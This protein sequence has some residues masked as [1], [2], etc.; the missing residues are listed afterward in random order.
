MP[1][2]IRDTV[3]GD[4]SFT[5]D[6]MSIIDTAP[7]QRLRGIKQL[8]TSYLVYPCAVH[9]RFE[10][11]LGTCHVAKRI[12]E[13]IEEN[14]GRRIRI[15]DRDRRV[16]Y[17]A[18]LL[19]DITHIPFGHTFEDERRIFE[20]HDQS[21]ERLE[22]FLDHSPI[23]EVLSKSG[24]YRSVR[25]VL[26][27]AQS[28]ELE[29]PFI[30]QIVS[31]TVC[32]DLLDYLKRDALFC[33]LSQSYDNR[34]FKY[35]T[36]T[37][38]NLAFDL[39]KNGLFRHDALSELINLLRIRYNL[40]ERVYYHHAK[41][42]AGAMISKA[43]ELALTEKKVQPQDLFELRDDSF[44]YFLKARC[45]SLRPVVS[46]LENLE[47]RWLYKRIYFLTLGNMS[48][49]GISK[50][51]QAELEKLYHY[52]EDE[53]RSKA[54]VEIARRL[55]IPEGSVIIYCPSTEMALKEAEVLVRIS[56]GAPRSLKDLNN[57]EVNVLIDKHR[58]LW[59][60]YVC[61]S[62]QYEDRFRKAE[63]ICEEIFGQ[64]N[65]IDLQARGQLSLGF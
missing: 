41:I 49:P 22:C 2:L 44:I 54:E 50:E 34:V 19:H 15:E 43:L 59:R 17:S 8:G 24:I 53:A 29:H 37:D 23:A 21:R 45:R 7:M 51:K 20:R 61:I 46:L 33:G 14:S 55:K 3:H 35:F 63:Q 56:D 48:R 26:S 11:S 42:V 40:T 25:A 32:A 27:K 64:E 30:H 9:T 38:D 65:M 39:N 60:F 10:H 4:I 58:S 62:L 47:R 31:G 36:I 28:S 18:A 57:P 1:K 16:I 6:E 12:V 13:S 5:D 52:N